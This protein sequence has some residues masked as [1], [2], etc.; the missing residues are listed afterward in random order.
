M[1][2]YL[3]A[4]DCAVAVALAGGTL[5]QDIAPLCGVDV[6]R[7]RAGDG[8]WGQ[9]HIERPP[10]FASVLRSIVCF[11]VRKRESLRNYKLGNAEE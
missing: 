2:T 10:C 7:E 9:W 3:V 1:D 4:A 6:E 11:T 5:I 8:R